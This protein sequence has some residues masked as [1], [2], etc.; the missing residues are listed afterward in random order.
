[1]SVLLRYTT[2]EGTF[3]WRAGDDEDRAV[4]L[5]RPGDHVLDVVVVAGAVDVR[6]VALVGLVL[7]VR[8][9]DRDPALLLLGSVV[10][11]I[12]RL[13]IGAALLGEH[14]GDRRCEGRLAVV[15]MTDRADVHMRL[16]PFEL[17]LRH[18][19]PLALAVVF[20]VCGFIRRTEEI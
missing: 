14:L 7:H 20:V 18:L 19:A 3:T 17:L 8:G 11:L 16:V 10:D 2:I 5:R 4:H 13:L 15:D 6:V 12:E 1:M 9:R